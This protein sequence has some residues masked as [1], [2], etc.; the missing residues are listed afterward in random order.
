MGEMA[1]GTALE[2]RTDLLGGAIKDQRAWTDG[3]LVRLLVLW[4]YGGVWVDMDMIFLRNLHVL[5][6]DEWVTQWDC[7]STSLS[8][9]LFFSFFL[10]NL[11]ADCSTA[12]R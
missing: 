11:L 2:G 8:V 9:F 7:Y 12:R 1:L 4:N 6:E 5:T 3:D 10:F